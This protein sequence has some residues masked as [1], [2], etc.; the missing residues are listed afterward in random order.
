MDVEN[1]RLFRRPGVIRI[2]GLS[3]SC[4]H[5]AVR[6]GTFPAPVRIGERAVVWG[7]QDILEWIRS[8]PNAR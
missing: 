5:K 7:Q 2:T 6:D 4:L 8:R 1:E 3:K